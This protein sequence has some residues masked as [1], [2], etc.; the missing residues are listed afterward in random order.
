MAMDINEVERRYGKQL[1]LIGNIDPNTLGLGTPEQVI[2][3]VR[4]RIVDLAPG[5]GYAVGA[6][7]G[8]AY[9]TRLENYEAM[10]RCAF[11]YGV[12]PITP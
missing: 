8:I 11:E 10:R 9:Y 6:S 4:Q 12:Y 7:P 3:E 5:G 1:S 2:A